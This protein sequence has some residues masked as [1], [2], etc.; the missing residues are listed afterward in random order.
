MSSKGGSQN[1]QGGGGAVAPFRPPPPPTLIKKTL[2]RMLQY[3]IAVCISSGGKFSSLLS[4]VRVA[5]MQKSNPLSWYHCT[6]FYSNLRNDLFSNVC[7]VDEQ[8]CCVYGKF[9]VCTAHGLQ[10]KTPHFPKHKFPHTR[11]SDAPDIKT[12]F[13]HSTGCAV[14]CVQTRRHSVHIPGVHHGVQL[15]WSTLPHGPL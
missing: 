7:T 5:K 11:T 9:M 14:H 3:C 4:S 8:F 1:I 12:F 13:F 2:V 10:C 6:I 15:Y